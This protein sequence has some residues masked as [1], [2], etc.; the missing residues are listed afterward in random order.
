MAL[1][2]AAKLTGVVDASQAQLGSGLTLPAQRMKLEWTGK[3]GWTGASSRSVNM[4]RSR[5]RRSNRRRSRR[6]AMMW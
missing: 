4:R 3:L 2:V 5:R 6:K 1:G